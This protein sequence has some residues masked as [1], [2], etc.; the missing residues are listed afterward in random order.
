MNTMTMQDY[1]ATDARSVKAWMDGKDDGRGRAFEVFRQEAIRCDATLTE[2]DI[3]N[4]YRVALANGWLCKKRHRTIM[5]LAGC[6]IY[7]LAI[8]YIVL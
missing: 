6:A 2:A 4:R 5:I 7:T 3:N 1:A 8:L